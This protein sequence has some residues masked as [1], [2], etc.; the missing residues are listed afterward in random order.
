MMDVTNLFANLS[1]IFLHRRFKM[2]ASSDETVLIVL[3]RLDLERSKFM[4]A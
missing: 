3:H 2:L 4:S 1:Y